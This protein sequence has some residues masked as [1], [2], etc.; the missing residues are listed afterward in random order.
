VQ[1]FAFSAF[2]LLYQNG[3]SSVHFADN[4]MYHDAG[5]VVLQLT[6][7]KVAKGALDC[8]GSIVCSCT[9]VNRLTYLARFLI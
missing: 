9:S 7:L 3:L 8:V 6:G 5:T 2:N 1:V 4:V